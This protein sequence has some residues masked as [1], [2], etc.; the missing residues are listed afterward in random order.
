MRV[1]WIIKREDGFTLFE[2]TLVLLLVTL[3]YSLVFPGF[4]T[5]QNRLEENADIML[6]TRDLKE[7][8]SEVKGK[9]VSARIVFYP[10]Q[11]YYSLM[12]GSTPLNRPLLGLRL[13]EEGDIIII[14]EPTGSR[15][16]QSFL[17]KGK[18]GASYRFTINTN[19]E[20]EVV[21]E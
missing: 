13:A 9:G 11:G 3:L 18:S 10:E 2:L 1:F 19:E 12:M 8:Q 20:L 5:L 15:E 16:D 4:D 14:L 17:L 7:L 6:L 21:R